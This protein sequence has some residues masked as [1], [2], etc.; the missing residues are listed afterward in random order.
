MS[1]ELVMSTNL[2]IL[3]CP[4]LLLPLILPSVRVLSNESALRITWP[5][6]W[7]FSFSISLFNEYSGLISFRKTGLISLM[8]KW[9]LRVFSST[10][11]WK[12]HFF[13]AQPSLWS[14]S[15]ICTWLLEK[16]LLWLYGLLLTKWCLC[17]FNMLSRFFIVFLPRSKHLLISWLESLSAVILEIQENKICYCL[18]FFPFNLPWSGRTGCHDIKFLNVEF[19]ASFFTFLFHPIKR[20]FSSSSLSAIRVVSS[21]YLRLLI[22]PWAI[23]IPAHVWCTL[24]I[25]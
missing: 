6:Y 4:L 20:I 2:L 18:H 15:H 14:N 25:S 17:F 8:Y 11:I 24:H 23:L 16:L 3:C 13:G 21:A 12:N 5:K 7:S 19:P 10:T 22:F 1:I 9:L